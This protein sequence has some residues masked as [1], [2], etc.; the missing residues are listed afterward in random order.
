MRIEQ[1][2]ILC[3]GILIS[4]ESS[5]AQN[6]SARSNEISLH[7]QSPASD[8]GPLPTITWIVPRMEFTTS[9]KNKIDVKAEVD[10]RQPLKEIKLSIGK[11]ND[12]SIIATKRFD[13][14]KDQKQYSVAMTLT[15]PDGGSFL[16]LEV[17]T[18]QG[19]IVSEKR[20]ITAGKGAEEMMIA[21]DR[22]D[23]AL[24]FATNRYD[25]WDDLVNP[26]DDAH[27]IA[28]VLKEKYGFIVELVEDPTTE[29][30]WEKLR[31]Y[32]ERKF[33]VQDQLFVFFAGHGH[34]DESF[35]EGYVV[36]KNSQSKDLSK[37]TYLSHNRLRGV[38]NNIPCRH[39]LLTMDV[40]FGG[41]LDPII[42]SRGASEA[43]VSINQM[44]VRKWGHKTRKYLTSGGKE[45]VSDGVPGKHSPFAG[46]LIE[47]L[48]SLG[49][50]DHLLTLGELQ[51]NL[52]KLKQL[53]RFG[54]FGEDEP[55]S[56]FIFVG[57]R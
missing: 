19:F 25:N 5:L 30:I 22:K 6:L 37:S 55:L 17:T 10:A 52:E 27:E 20:L 51:T 41:T 44:L 3:A 33:G 12:G 31:E 18:E 14:N 50:E 35:G 34:Y 16:L 42:A 24:L 56:D 49:G 23:Y 8:S 21:L 15:L 46:K 57:K 48:N 29:K 7:Q 54:S 43:E 4:A 2:L 39:I 28:R 38:I 9:A 32:N 13:T 40:C 36:A 45:Y 26:I 47:S 53:P 11:S 1:F